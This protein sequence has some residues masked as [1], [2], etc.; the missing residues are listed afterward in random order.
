MML[1]FKKYFLEY[2][3]GDPLTRATPRNG[4]NPHIDVSARKHANVVK[5]EYK[6][7]HPI[8][9]AISSGRANNVSMKGMPLDALLKA[10][11]THFNIGTKTLGNSKV[12]AEMFEDEEGVRGAILRRKKTNGL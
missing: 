8:V 4:K 5:K 12:E 2:Y 6:H 1:V 10:Y 7:K 11:D 9:D 3:K